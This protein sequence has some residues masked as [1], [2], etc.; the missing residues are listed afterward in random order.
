[1]VMRVRPEPLRG[2][3]KVAVAIP[4]YNYGHYLADCVRSVLDQEGVDLDVIIVDDASPDGSGA[5]AEQ[6]AATDPRVRAIARDH[7]VG[8][9]K[10]F[11]EGLDAVDGDF[12]VLLSADDLLAPGSLARSAA[13]LQAHPDVGM[14]HGFALTFADE[15]P[16][17]RGNLRSWTI[18]PGQE[19]LARICGNGGNPV[20]TPEVMMRMSTM[21]DLVGYDPRVPH[22]CDFLMWLRAAAHGSIGRLNGVDQAY[23]RVHGANMH[24][25]QYGGA[26]T[27]IGQRHHAFEIF[28]EEDG[29]DLPDVDRLRGAARWALSQ[30]ALG[31][32][33]DTY[34]H[35]PEAASPQLAKELAELAVELDPAAADCRLMQALRRTERR[36]EAGKGPIV[37]PRVTALRKKVRH[38]LEWRRRRW[39][40]VESTVKAR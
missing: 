39:S 31:I 19:W 29:K 13:L 40:G 16:P 5:V 14:V 23:Y 36:V 28:F 27:D 11:N 37:P 25:E 24:T 18:W 15:L 1:M 17:A 4:C 22:A 7:N 38:H 35:G 9:I 30:E 6:L 26:I 12:V 2:R 32:A 10:T 20:A 33:L 8:H 34:D 3:P 21:R